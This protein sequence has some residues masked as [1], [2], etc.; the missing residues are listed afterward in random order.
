MEVYSNQIDEI[1]SAYLTDSYRKQLE[2]MTVT[3]NNVKAVQHDINRHYNIIKTMIND[4]RYKDIG[5]YL[6]DVQGQFRADVM[7]AKTGNSIIDSIINFES[8]L[9]GI[10]HDRVN[11]IAV[12]VPVTLEI[13]EF[14]LT[15]V[16][17]NLVRNAFQAVKNIEDGIVDIEIDYQRGM[18]LIKIVNDYIGT[19]RIPVIKKL[20]EINTSEVNGFGLLNVETVV[21]KNNGDI[22]IVVT[23]DKFYVDVLLYSKENE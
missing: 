10:D 3:V 5:E 12:N 1:A 6:T 4:N 9:A 16:L 14:E 19:A 2:T 18:L 7:L 11:I 8:E 17:S 23:K 20:K 15:V 13:S 22:N 21:Q